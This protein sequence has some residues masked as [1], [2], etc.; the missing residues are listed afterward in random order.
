MHTP[1]P[2]RAEGTAIYAG[3]GRTAI[4]YFHSAADAEAAAQAMTN[5]RNPM[6]EAIDA[7]IFYLDD[8]ASA[9]QLLFPDA[10]EAYKAE[11]YARD[12][13]RFWAALDIYNQRRLVAAALARRARE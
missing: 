7:V 9:V 8:K 12:A 3:E 13:F 2:W 1:T 4:G 10:V 11:W 5:A 6:L